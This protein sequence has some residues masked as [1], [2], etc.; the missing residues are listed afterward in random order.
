MYTDVEQR[1]ILVRSLI[2]DNPKATC[3]YIQRKTAIKIE[4]VYIGGMAEAFRDAG[5]EPPRTFKRKNREER[6]AIIIDYIKQHPRAGGQIISRDTKIG[7]SSAFKTTKEA[8]DAAGVPY[9]RPIDKQLQEEKKQT[10]IAYVKKHPLITA[11]ALQ[12]KFHTKLYNYFSSIDEI[13]KIVGIKSPNRRLKGSH[14]IK[15]K[16]QKI[17][18]EFIKNN[19]TPTQREINTACKT[20]VQLIFKKGIYEAY[21]K[22]GVNFPFERLKTY[23]VGKKEIRERWKYYEN[24]IADKLLQY[25]KIQRLVKTKR[26]FADIILERR[27]KKAI[28]EVKDYR[29]HEI[30]ISQIKQLYKYLEDCNYT[31][32]ILVCPKKPKRDAL[33]IGDKKI[34]IVNDKHIEDIPYF[35]NKY[36]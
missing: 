5:V 28:I 2:K 34:F 13:Y 21:K 7:I 26:G 3:A 15:I 32:G 24:M 6:R 33:R 10:I 4:R 8:F 27:K 30:S 1:K 9:P 25:G 35:M 17:V 19:S 36:G 11:T 31:L 22:A 29:S 20:H 18:I 23:G 16:K 14:L 12:K